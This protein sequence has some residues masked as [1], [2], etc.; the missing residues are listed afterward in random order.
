MNK[1]NNYCKFNLELKLKVR[2]LKTIYL[3]IN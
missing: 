1:D 2:M 3:S